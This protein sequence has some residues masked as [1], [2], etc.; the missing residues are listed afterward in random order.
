MATA[1]GATDEL[2]TVSVRPVPAHLEVGEEAF[3][4]L[5]KGNAVRGQFIALE[6]ILE[7]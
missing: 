3:H 5:V 6:V 7:V 1:E 2:V 4:R